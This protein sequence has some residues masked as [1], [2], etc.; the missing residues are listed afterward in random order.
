[1][2]GERSLVPGGPPLA[3]HIDEVVLNLTR[4]PGNSA[5][6]IR[7]VRLSGA[8]NATLERGGELVQISYPTRDLIA[9]LNEL[10]KIRF[11]ELPSKYTTRYSVVLKEDGSVATSALRMT[12]A[13]STSACFAVTEYE[14]CIT[15][16]L[17]GPRELESIVNR[18]FDDVEKQLRSR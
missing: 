10:Y 16:G 2:A 11:F 12:D 14:K 6:P 8:G 9:L 13:G 3:Y 7:R 5:F 4:H 15:Y 17:D 1:M 18:V